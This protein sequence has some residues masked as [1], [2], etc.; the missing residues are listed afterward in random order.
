LSPKYDRFDFLDE[1]EWNNDGV[2]IRIKNIKKKK[3]KKKTKMK[4]YDYSEDRSYQK[5]EK[6]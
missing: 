4:N 3:N 2:R 1:D 5:K 6:R